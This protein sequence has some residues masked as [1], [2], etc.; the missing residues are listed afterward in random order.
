M[1]SS[2]STKLGATTSL[3]SQ[4]ART[5]APAYFDF[6]AVASLAIASFALILSVFQN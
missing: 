2:A 1:K 6:A 4:D 5:T 3:G